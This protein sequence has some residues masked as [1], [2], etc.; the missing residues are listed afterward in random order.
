MDAKGKKNKLA[1]RVI[2][3]VVAIIIVLLVIV[4]VVGYSYFK[5]GLKP[6]APN[7]N[8]R[9]EI[10]IPVGSTSKQIGSI[11]EEK[12][13]VK[14]G[15]VFDYYVKSKKIANFKAGY[16]ALEPSMTLNQIAQRLQ[17]GG[18]S[19]PLN[20]GRVLIR[21]G[22]TA[23]TI[24]QAIEKN[25]RFKKVDFLKLLNDDKFINEL[26]AKYPDLLTSAVSA[27]KVRYRLEGYLYP[28]TY[29]VTKKITL[30]QLIEEMVA[31]SDQELKPY[32][33]EIKKQKKSVQWVLTLASLVE[34]EGENAADR[35]KIAGVFENRLDQ[36][37]RLQ[38]DISVLYALNKHKEVVTYKDLEV[39]SP[40]NLY[41][42]QG[43]GPGP[44]NNPSVASVKAVLEPQDKNKEYIYF[45]ADT[46]TGKVYFSE[47]YAQ[48][49]QTIAKIEAKN[50]KN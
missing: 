26:R 42:N 11:L 33:A 49:Q 48:H 3:S 4:A 44:F 18:A 6:L 28:A 47:T 22:V 41:K 8:K 9:I 36:K 23:E 50:K 25:T 46:K 7:S 16:Y 10:K 32:Y 43:V 17:K 45:Y 35:A 37:M 30:K 13:V 27:K 5:S 34:R 20:S 15:F 1:T 29:S 38:S 14:S 31:K 40:Y 2:G 24:G 19:E 39:D 12:N 21:E